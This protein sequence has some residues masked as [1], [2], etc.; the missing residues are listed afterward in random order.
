MVAHVY[1]PSYVGGRGRKIVVQGRSRRFY[2]KNNLKEVKRA[3]D[4]AQV[5]ECLPSQVQALSSNLNITK[6][7]NKNPC[8]KYQTIWLL[9]QTPNSS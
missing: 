1:N 8:S 7:K 3:V 2:L 4:V 5:A 6:N 9:A